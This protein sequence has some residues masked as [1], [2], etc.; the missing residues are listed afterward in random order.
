MKFRFIALFLIAALLFTGCAASALENG[1][2]AAEKTLHPGTGAAATR[3]Q[4]GRPEPAAN[5]PALTKEQ[6]QTVALEHAGFTADQVTHLRT[7]YEIDD[8]V[9]QYEVQ[10]RRGRWEYT[11]EIHAENGTILS[12]D[13][14]D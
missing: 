4:A 6:A 12:Y 2:G 8:G 3:P 14:D 7:K 10:F 1:L 13:K 9:P 5:T 11:Y